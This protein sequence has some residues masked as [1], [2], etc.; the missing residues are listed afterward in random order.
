V[1][2]KAKSIHNQLTGETPLFG[3]YLDTGKT[4]G[5]VLGNKRASVVLGSVK[6]LNEKETGSVYFYNEK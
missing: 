3:R 6:H 1:F 2:V 4:W 5:R